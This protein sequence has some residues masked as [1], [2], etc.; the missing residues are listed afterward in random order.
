MSSTDNGETDRAGPDPACLYRKVRLIRRFEERAI[1]LVR[2]GAIPGGIHPCI[3]QE[4]VPAGVC[5]A[6]RGDDAVLSNHRGHGHLLAKG[7]PPGTLLAELAGRVTGVARGR[8][9]SLHPSD[10]A[11]GVY[12]ASATVGH[13]AAIAA[14]VAFALAR[15]GDAVV[16]SF[17]GDGAVNQGALLESLNV[18][19]LWRLPVLFVCE[20]NGFAT[21][22]QASAA[23]AG[24]IVGRAEAFG[25]PATTVDG[26]DPE[27]VYEA[28]TRGV[29]RARAGD[30]PVF[31]EFDTYR[32]DA[33]HTFE[34]RARLRYRDDDEVAR[35]RARDPLRLQGDRIT[36]EKRS[37]LDAEIEALLDDAVRFALESPPP[38]VVD[39]LD[40]RYATAI[41][42]HRGV[43]GA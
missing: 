22:L 10:L 1:E 41:P 43:A 16:V 40:Y 31:L 17:F 4:A 27:A 23:I 36:A 39:V 28:T 7:S 20:N 3:G 32:F 38:D 26:M 9:G 8:G 19:A 25:I 34:Y 42:A 13:G 15:R 11:V 2:S 18:A 35:W 21:T 12:G 37:L 5:A 6:L 29:A 30:G 24:S 33:H 14:G